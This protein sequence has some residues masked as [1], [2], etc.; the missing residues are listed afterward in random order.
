M[1]TLCYY[2]E[3]GT[4]IDATLLFVAELFDCTFAIR[5][6]EMNYREVTIYCNE[7]DVVGIQIAISPI[8]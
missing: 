8:L 4:K 3:R 7:E 1:K 5:T 2:V 6:A